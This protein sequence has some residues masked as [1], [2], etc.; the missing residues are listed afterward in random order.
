MQDVRE[1]KQKLEQEIELLEVDFQRRLSSLKGG[2]DELK[3]PTRYIKESP[4]KSVAIAAGIGFA[5]GLLKKKRKRSY[6]GTE[7]GTSE[8]ESRRS[9]GITSFI[10]EELQHL[11]AQKAMMYLSEIID[12]Q[13]SGLKKRPE[14][15]Q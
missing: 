4:V 8:K 2:M 3:E 6:P 13:L 15:D 11:A 7:Q 12:R 10:V 9:P 14:S 5:V 1:R